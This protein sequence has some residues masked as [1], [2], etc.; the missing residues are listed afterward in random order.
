M[1]ECE[2]TELQIRYS[3]LHDSSLFLVHSDIGVIG[4]ILAN[5]SFASIVTKSE[6]IFEFQPGYNVH[7]FEDRIVA[8]WPWGALAAGPYSIHILFII[9]VC[10]H[11]RARARRRIVPRWRCSVLH[12]P[13]SISAL[14]RG[15]RL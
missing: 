1:R 4:L 6:S 10:A 14:R 15:L 11:P 9:R 8:A 13:S 2:C 7:A 12:R 5:V 3:K